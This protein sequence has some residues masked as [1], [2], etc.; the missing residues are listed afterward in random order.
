[1]GR[2]RHPFAPRESLIQ[3]ACVDHWRLL[4]IPGSLVAAIPNAFAHGQP[5]LTKG[6]PDLLVISTLLGQLTGFIELKADGGTP[7]DDQ[8]AV[9][10]LML[11][12]GI[13]YAMTWGRDEPIFLLEQW[14]AVRRATRSQVVTKRNQE[15]R[16]S[17]TREQLA[18]LEIVKARRRA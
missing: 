15:W 16:N 8:I 4:G 3:A 10:D 11:A 1:M 12:S 18:A 7:S 2:R 5:G 17:L 14:G 9:R 13:P 6:L